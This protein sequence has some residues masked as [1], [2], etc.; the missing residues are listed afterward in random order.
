M[1]KDVKLM[2]H[3]HLALT[4][5]EAVAKIMCHARMVMFGIVSIS[6]VIAQQESNRTV[7]RV[8]SV[9]VENIGLLE[10]V[11][12]VQMV[13]L[14]LVHNARVLIKQ[15]VYRFLKLNGSKINVYAMKDILR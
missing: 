8:C 13:I 15:D 5:V 1:V 9:L 3:V 4:L 10:L 6:H 12:D 7:T 2:G 14:I 11:A